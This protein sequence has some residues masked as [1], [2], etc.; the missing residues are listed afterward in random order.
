[1]KRHVRSSFEAHLGSRASE[2]GTKHDDPRSVIG[3]LLRA[4]LEAIL[5]KLE[6]ATAAVSALLI[7]DFVLENQRLV[8]EVQSSFQRGR[9]GVVGSLALGN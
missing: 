7:L 6:V 1:M 4:R 2:V 5:K 3:E 9:N 8:L